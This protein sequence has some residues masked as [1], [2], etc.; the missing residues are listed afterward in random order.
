VNKPSLLRPE[1]ELPAGVQAFVTTRA[2]GCSQGAYASFNLAEHV[3]DDAQ[4]V[5]ANRQLLLEQLRAQL[6]EKTEQRELALQWVEQVHGIDVLHAALPAKTPAPT[7]DAIYTTTTGLV[8]G[9]LT[10]DC[11]PVLFATVDG[12]AVAVAHAGWRGLCNGVLEATVKQFQCAPSQIIAWLGPAIAACHFQVG[13]EVRAAFLAKATSVNHQVTA[14]AF[15]P[16]EHAGKWQADL[17]ALAHIRLLALGLTTV[18]G[19]A[20][21]TVCHADAYYSYRQQKI[22]GRFATLIVK[23]A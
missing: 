6:C 16:S 18:S 9:V 20:Q 23:T 8:C 5:L 21:C 19:D 4:S 13:D 14:A 2:G 11:L 15:Q 3:D 17:Y 7:A 22:T 12:S 1:W 10:A